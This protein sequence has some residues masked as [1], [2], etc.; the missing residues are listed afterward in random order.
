MADAKGCCQ[1]IYDDESDDGHGGWLCPVTPA[2]LIH[3]HPP[4]PLPVGRELIPIE[5]QEGFES[6]T[7]IPR[8]LTYCFWDWEASPKSPRTFDSLDPEHLKAARDGGCVFARKFDKRITLTQWLEYMRSSFP[9]TYP[10]AAEDRASGGAREAGNG[11]RGSN[12]DSRDSR[13]GRSRSRSRERNRRYSLLLVLWHVS[14]W[15]TAAGGQNRCPA[16]GCRGGA[17]G[18]AE[19]ARPSGRICAACSINLS[20]SPI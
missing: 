12:R 20:V 19:H 16:D 13:R 5:G 8:R 7:V 10:P 17:K 4:L 15:H 6:C 9:A 18:P 3:D 2:A 11:D 1:H 14:P